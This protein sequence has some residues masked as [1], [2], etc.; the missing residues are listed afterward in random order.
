MKKNSIKVLICL[1]SFWTFFSLGYTV[2][3]SPRQQQQQPQQAPP[4]SPPVVVQQIKRTLYQVKGGSG[5]NTAFYIADREVIAID[6]KMSEESTRQKLAAIANITPL[7]VTTI[8]LTH[9]DGDHVN[10][11]HGFPRGLKIISHAETR[12]YMDEAFKEEHLRAYLPTAT[13]TD[14][15]DLNFGSKRI[16]LLHFGPAHTS[17]DAVIYF[18]EEKV[19]HVG[20]LV[21]IG[22]DPLIHRHKNGNYR[23][24][25]ATLRAVLN[26]NA[27]TFL[28][29]HAEPATRADIEAAITS[30]EERWAKVKT[31]VDEGKT[32][33]EIK[34]ILNVQERPA[35]PGRP[36]WLSLPELIYLELTEKK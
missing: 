12:R 19:A 23:G 27:D 30:L 32:L 22:R 8:L 24:V 16:E 35:Q 31:L 11:L 20:D 36:R 13:F 33:E 6:G 7:P 14:K 25:I 4:A 26:L 3:G 1:L 29:G 9:S 18:P 2:P 15:M 5:A 17:G 34:K 21:F 28:S 10:G